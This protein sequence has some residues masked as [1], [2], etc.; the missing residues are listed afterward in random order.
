M[1]TLK[2]AETPGMIIEFTYHQAKC[3]V[4]LVGS[5]WCVDRIVSEVVEGDVRERVSR[6]R[7]RASGSG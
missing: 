6:S 3:A 1:R 5:G 7:R 4:G 2:K